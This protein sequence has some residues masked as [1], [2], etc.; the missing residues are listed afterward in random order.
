MWRLR[1]YEKAVHKCQRD[2][3][4][5]QLKL[6]TSGP[7]SAGLTTTGPLVFERRGEIFGRWRIGSSSAAHFMNNV[8][9]C[10][11][12]MCDFLIKRKV[13]VSFY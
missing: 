5:E 2:R 13:L 10:E 4:G 11:T 1:F 9:N 8:A 12:R 3:F 7:V 6:M